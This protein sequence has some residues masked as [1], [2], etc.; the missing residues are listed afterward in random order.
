MF[1][2]TICFIVVV[3]VAVVG[4]VVSFITVAA[5]S[6]VTTTAVSLLLQHFQ[7]LAQT[8]RGVLQ[9]WHGPAR[10]QHEGGEV[11]AHP[12]KERVEP[13]PGGRV[14]AL[15]LQRDGQ[16]RGVRLHTRRRRRLT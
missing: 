1:S 7:Q 10:V 4:V 12:G 3:A 9:V 13:G 8:P 5:T 16:R 11:H 2:T 6:N 15:L 14:R